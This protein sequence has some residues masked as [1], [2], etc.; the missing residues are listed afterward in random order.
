MEKNVRERSAFLSRP[1]S[2]TAKRKARQSKAPTFV[3]LMPPEAP[4]C[5]SCFKVFL[6]FPPTPHLFTASDHEFISNSTGVTRRNLAC[7]QKKPKQ[8]QQKKPPPK[9]PSAGES[10]LTVSP[11]LRSAC[12][13]SRALSLFFSSANA[14]CANHFTL[15]G[16]VHFI[17]P[18]NT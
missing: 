4:C 13:T 10:N 7:E 2:R 6:F 15:R 3:F 18:L 17:L 1:L 16:K 5:R 9:D 12:F 14:S 8:Q 11:S